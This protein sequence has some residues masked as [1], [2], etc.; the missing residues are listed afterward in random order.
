MHVV[1]NIFDDFK[2]KIEKLYFLIMV[3]YFEG[4][5]NNQTCTK[6]F[7]NQNELFS[8]KLIP[9]VTLAI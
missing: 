5:F 8:I 7:I 2:E 6:D 9:Y 3:A 4:E 1:M